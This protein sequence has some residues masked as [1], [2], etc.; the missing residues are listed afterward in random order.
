MGRRICILG[1]GQ[2]GKYRAL[3]IERHLAGCTEIWGL[4]NGY[5]CYPSLTQT[6]AWTRYF[7]LHQHDYLTVWAKEHSGSATY[8]QDLDGLDCP[9]YTM[10]RIPVVMKQRALCLFDICVQY[11]SNYFLGSPSLMLMQ[12]LYEHDM[13][14]TV[15]ELRSYGIDQLDGDHAQQRTAWAWW[16]RAIH[17][18]GIALTGTITDFML[19]P[20]RDK[21]LEGLRQ[22]VGQQ[23]VVHVK[24]EDH[25]K[26]DRAPIIIAGFQG[27]G[28]SHLAH[29]CRRAGVR[30][31]HTTVRQSE[32]ECLT[33]EEVVAR[34]LERHNVSGLREVT[35]RLLKDQDVSMTPTPEMIGELY[36]Y[37]R[38]REAQGVAW[39]FNCPCAVLFLDAFR[40][41]FP[42]ANFIFAMRNPVAV[43]ESWFASRDCDSSQDGLAAYLI[44]LGHLH[45]SEVEAVFWNVDG[46][47]TK[48]QKRLS[49]I[50]GLPLDL[51]TGWKG[52]IP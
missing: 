30:M 39:G 28:A 34:E 49:E 9:V 38:V 29:A 3:G 35:E 48:E 37:R 2:S 46:D 42:D 33:I 7:E 40:E 18:R 45:R 11:N 52:V 50:I 17:D 16:L 12:L 23:I 13:G 27:S 20:E 15:E 8:F 22:L 43:G 41:V 31:W 32:C 4:N 25:A 26:N 44:Q 6:K 36:R 5:L 10:E 24:A 19:E 51:A 47:Q 21:G 14:Q 1:M